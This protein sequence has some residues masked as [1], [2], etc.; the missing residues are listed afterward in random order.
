MKPL[1][2]AIR[3]LL[4]WGT[5]SCGVVCAILGAIAGVMVVTMGFWKTVLVAVFTFI[6][7]FLGGV[8]NKP[9]AIKRFLNRIL[10]SN[11]GR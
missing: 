5:P 11:D 10:P 6:G 7:A 9:A 4:K 1:N 2:D 8:K 3:E